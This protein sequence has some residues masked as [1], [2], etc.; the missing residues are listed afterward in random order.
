MPYIIICGCALAALFILRFAAI[1]RVDPPLSLEV[2]HAQIIG[3]REINADAFEWAARQGKTMLIVADGIGTGTRGRTAALAATDSIART[4]ELQGLLANP[5]FF[6][7]QAFHNANEAVLRYIPDGTSGANVLCILLDGGTLYYALAGNCQAAVY[8]RGKLIPLSEG[9]TLDVLARNAF[10]RQEI[11]REE[12]R[13]VYRERRVYNYVG[14]DGFND[15]EMFD[16]PVALKQGDIIVLMTD[17][18]YDFCPPLDMETI[19]QTK[20]NCKQK[21]QAIM[22]LLSERDDPHQDNAT[23]VLAKINRLKNG[24]G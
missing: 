24:R 13:E 22:N 10:K 19:L 2:A 6:F 8:R 23:I 1:G 20:R 15:L 17:G 5:S 3:R 7:K 11:R 4:F 18:V 21:A 12:A 16:V 14:K 9:Q